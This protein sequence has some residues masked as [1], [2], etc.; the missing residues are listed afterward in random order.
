[1]TGNQTL[2][3]FAYVPVN[4]LQSENRKHQYTPGIP[5]EFTRPSHADFEGLGVFSGVGGRVVPVHQDFFF[6]GGG[7]G[8]HRLIPGAIIQK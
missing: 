2:A 8:T 3:S 6:W 5:W 4:I 1:M 7:G